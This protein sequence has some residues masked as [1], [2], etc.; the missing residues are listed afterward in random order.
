MLFAAALL[1]Q[2]A[3]AAPAATHLS[4]AGTWQLRL[5]PQNEGHSQ[6][7][8]TQSF[9]GDS[10]FLPGST[11]QG[12]FGTKTAGPTLGQLSRPYTYEGAAWYQKP[13][14]IP[15]SWS[16]QRITLFIERAHW[17]TE[18]W[19]DGKAFGSANSLTTPHEYDLTSA[20]TPG[21]HRITVCV[22]NSYKIDIG[23]WS[24]SFTD[25]SQTNWNGMI[26][27][28]ELRASPP[29]FLE[30][31][32]AYPDLKSKSVRLVAVVRN[33]TGAPADVSLSAGVPGVTRKP[34]PARASQPG[35][36]Q[37][38]EI[39][40]PLG[41]SPRLWDEFDPQLY[42]A[43]VQLSAQAGGRSFVDDAD[44]SFGMRQISTHEGQFL[45]NGRPIFI[46]GTVESAVFPL[47]G[48]PPM[49]AGAW[50]R[51]FR[52][53]RSYGL[54]EFRFHSWC[55]P[56]AAFEAADRA[57]FLLQVEL[58]VWS[59]TVGKDPVLDDYM[60]AE[61]HR[62][63][64]AYGNHPSFT[65]FSMGN[66]LAGDDAFLDALVA[67]LKQGDSRRLYTFATDSRRRVP[68]PTSD[69]YTTYQTLH[70]RLRLNNT[71]FGKTMDGTDHDFSAAL[72]GITVPVITHEMGQ[73]AVHPSY[74]EIGEYT[75][76]LKPRNLEALRD[77]LAAHGMLDEAEAFQTASGKF[78]WSIYKEDMEA[79]LRTPHY[80]GFSLLALNDFPG[81]GE[82][83]VGL[84]DSLWNTKSILAP[85]EFREF[86]GPTVPLARFTKFVW[87]EGETFTARA[88]LAHYGKA[89][90]RNAVALWT[91]QDDAGRIWASG[92]FPAV[93]V[94][95]GSVTPL[96]TIRL[97]L[98]R[99]RSAAHLKITL[100][101]AGTE[102]SN[103]WDIWVYPKF[104]DIELPAGVLVT[105]AFDDA[106][107][108]ALAAGKKVVFLLPPGQT[109]D[110]L[111]PAQF[112]PVFWS[113]TFGATKKIIA[114]MGI[115]CDPSH[116]ALAEFPTEPHS[117]WQWWELNEGSRAFDLDRAPPG[118]RPIV[119][120]IDDF[121][122]ARKLGA[123]FEAR[124]GEGKL[125]AVSLD[126]QSNLDRR[127]A[128]RQLLRSLLDYA[129]S[130]R[131]DPQQSLPLDVVQ[132]LLATKSAPQ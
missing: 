36:E 52:I 47:T 37:S 58:P 1:A 4:L 57:G 126:L 76:V 117:G 44:V 60:R 40:V 118:Y 92:R 34:I 49:T 125:L 114:T 12:G 26:G 96:G 124:V 98:T 79:A 132:G 14:V 127:P 123:V 129:A 24:S 120:V 77:L 18:V 104:G 81:Q 33:T 131:F 66:E 105:G 91:A 27:E 110:N 5:D 39:A 17:E 46:R 93:N 28:I 112:L 31:V 107:R 48:Y 50:D 51:I 43:D 74:D 101:V 70:G 68:G 75:G 130:D 62:I 82:A 3:H 67:E 65:M 42:E 115:L 15:E 88:E 55:P 10:I 103:H 83:L 109:N 13:V 53:A 61:G 99:V 56:E 20:L 78:S 89:P 23:R 35:E 63:L 45:I 86:C 108:T 121:H 90:L 19:V 2:A 80:G 97:P 22:D 94:P 84:V 128:A 6:Q 73:W 87:T 21:P 38:I 106:A 41:N 116:P 119:Q 69:Y 71:R 16:G 59:H 9:D 11:D 122:F 102:A 30:S 54:N 95:L 100:R 25:F 111:V 72:E 32:N 7:W 8:F 85:E 64:K 29:V 113:S